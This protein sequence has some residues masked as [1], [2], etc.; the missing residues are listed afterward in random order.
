MIKDILEHNESVQPTD[1]TLAKLH[2]DFPQCFDKEGKFNIETFRRLVSGHA[3]ITRESYGLDFLGRSY[4]S[5]ISNTDTDTVIVPDEANNAKP[6]NAHSQNVYI[7]GDNLDGLKHLLK[8]YAGEIKCIYIDPP[9]N[10][11]EDDFVYSDRF[12]FTVNDLQDKLGIDE[13]QAARIF[14]LTTRRSSSH[15]AWLTFMAARLPL[16]YDLLAKDGVIFVSIDDNEQA[17]LKLLLDSIFGEENFVG[18]LIIK[19][20]TD[21]NPTQINTE[22]EYILCYSREKEHLPNWSRKNTNRLLI[23]DKYKALKK[24]YENAFDIEKE[25]RKWIKANKSN[26]PQLAH[27]DKVDERGVFSSS[28]NSSNT[29]PGG[30]HYDILHPITGKPCPIPAYGW[31]WPK[32]TFEE[33]DKSGEVYW[34]KDET[35]QPHIKMRVEDAK[36]QLKTII[37]ED[38][39]ASTKILEDLF[40]I[41]K[42]FDNPKP[43]ETL[44]RLFDFVTKGDDIILDFFSGS[45]TTAHAVMQMNADDNGEGKRRYIMVQLDE[46]T[47][48]DSEARKAGYETIDQIG[49]ERIRRAAAKIR[50][51]N[52]LFADNLDLG[53]KHFTLKGVPQNT[54]DKI[55]DF[56]PHNPIAFEDTLNDFG[57]ATVLKTWMVRD[58]HGFCAEPERITLSKAEAYKYKNHLYILSGENLDENAMAA[59]VEQYGKDPHFP[60]AIVVFGYSLNYDQ[61][62]MLRANITRLQKDDNSVSLQIR[63]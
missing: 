16:A 13:E 20:A 50:E 10:T 46:P 40:G 35:T 53:F 48:P 26:L 28:S 33:Y 42:I 1:R 30:Y 43:L 27:Y 41:K 24:K 59:L 12:N 57:T 3:D 47:K 39:R 14:N 37:Y 9:Y 54:L 19:T 31:R 58:D 21:N 25:L 49:M 7:T 52:P 34:G 15:S 29:R 51:A 61:N 32:E 18:Q 23:Q 2:A 60:K 44:K 63:Y 22:H 45:S 4:A 62:A 55:E 5:L 17:N 11:G 36:E 8:S 6:E 56:D 38:G